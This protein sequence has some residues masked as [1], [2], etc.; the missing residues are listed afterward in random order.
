M[1]RSIKTSID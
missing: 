1:Y